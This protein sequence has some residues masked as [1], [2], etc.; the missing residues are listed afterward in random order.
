VVADRRKP[1]LFREWWPGSR[2]TPGVWGIPVPAEGE[3]VLPATL[4]V[5][6]VGFDRQG[7]RLGYGG[8]YYDRT[9]AAMPGR[10]LAIGVGFEQA[11][12]DTIHPQPHDVPMDVIVTAQGVHARDVAAAGTDGRRGTPGTAG[13]RGRGRCG[14]GRKP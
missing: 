8:G 1:L 10:P 12:L 14:E 9:L 3:A 13:V 6:L 11:L 5:P 7:Y 4:L 2:M